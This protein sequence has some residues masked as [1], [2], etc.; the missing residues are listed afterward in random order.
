MAPLRKAEEI[1]EIIFSF[2]CDKQTTLDGIP[3]ETRA[4]YLLASM[5]NT[6]VGEDVRQMAAV[7]LRRVISNE[8][9]DFYNKVQKNII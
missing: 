7:L 5:R 2:L 4:T 6:T 3:V 8:F 1:N 9:E